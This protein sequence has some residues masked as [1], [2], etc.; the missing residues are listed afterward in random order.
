MNDSVGTINDI[1]T[2]VSWV[3]SCCVCRSGAR[4]WQACMLSK[5][6]G[7][8]LNEILS[9]LVPTRQTLAIESLYVK[10]N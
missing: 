6:L 9:W 4:E 10:K 3:Q 2:Q 7:M 5:A 1:N 8:F